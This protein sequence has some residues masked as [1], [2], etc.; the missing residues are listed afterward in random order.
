MEKL[1]YRVGNREGKGWGCGNYISI[2]QPQQ[3]N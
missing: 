2:N 1:G 3:P